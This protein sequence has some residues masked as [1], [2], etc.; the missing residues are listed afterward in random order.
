VQPAFGA[1]LRRRRQ[2]AEL[3]L[4][5]LAAAVH[6]SKGYLSKVETGV[7]KPNR[8]LAH[9]LDRVLGTDGELMRMVPP[10]EREMGDVI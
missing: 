2:Q 10:T 5:R 9:L 4:S 1:E 8:T 3:S 7:A 6:Y